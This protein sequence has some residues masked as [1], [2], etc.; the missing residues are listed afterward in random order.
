M[1]SDRGG[2]LSLVVRV[3]PFYLIDPSLNLTEFYA[4]A[5]HSFYNR[6]REYWLTLYREVCTADLL[7]Y[8][9]GN[10]LLCWLTTDF[11]LSK[12]KSKRG[13]ELYNRQW[14]FPLQSE[15]LFPESALGRPEECALK[16]R[17][18]A[19]VFVAS[20]RAR[21]CR[22]RR[23]HS[24]RS[25]LRSFGGRIPIGRCLSSADII[26]REKNICVL[27]IFS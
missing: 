23:R 2:D 25:R 15:R 11:P 13:G 1:G 20:A 21:R 4:S 10:W 3:L 19:R 18:R 8:L 7:F 9:F 24:R 5:A 16:C 26:V 22:R 27:K 17:K 6:H 14:Y 12:V